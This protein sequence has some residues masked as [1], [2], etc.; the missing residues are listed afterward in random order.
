MKVHLIDGTFEL[1]RAFFGA[2]PATAPDGRE[3]GAVRGL[4]RGL[5]AMLRGEGITH[6]G[7]AFDTVIESFRNQLLTGYKTGEGLPVE[8]TSQ[9]ELAEQAA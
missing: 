5:H 2:P 7:A 8:L 6:A 3:V 4:L 9:F 1:F